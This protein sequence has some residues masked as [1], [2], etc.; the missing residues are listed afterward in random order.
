[1]TIIKKD[2][3]FV[4]IEI[5]KSENN[6]STI[7]LNSIDGC[8]MRLSNVKIQNDFDKFNHVDINCENGKGYVSNYQIEESKELRNFLLLLNQSIVPVLDFDKNNI[9]YSLI[10]DIVELIRRKKNGTGQNNS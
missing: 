7:W 5:S 2:V 6:K 10:Q 4:S 3:P 1:M 8:I 9:D